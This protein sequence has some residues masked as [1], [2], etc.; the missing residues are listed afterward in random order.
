MTALASVPAL[1]A[2]EPAPPATTPPDSAVVW[3]RS[4]PFVGLVQ[5]MLDVRLTA[6]L[7][8]GVWLILE[9]QPLLLLAALV[10]WMLVLLLVLLR[11]RRLAAT[12]MSHP[13]LHLADLLATAAMTAVAGL[14]SP[15]SFLLLSGALFAGLC[16]GR[17]G[18]WYLTPTYLVCWLLAA[19]ATMP[20]RA[21]AGL[22]FL[23]LVAVPVL[24][25]GLLF[26]GSSFQ[27]AVL[28]A[29][30]LEESARQEREL[31]AVAEERARLAREL[32]DSVTKSL[33]GIGLLADAM[34]RLVATDPERAAVQA[35][36]LASAA[37][38][39][40]QESRELLVSMRRADVRAGLAELLRQ[41]VQ[42]WE[43]QHGRR[44]TTR[45]PA[46]PAVD[47]GTLYEIGALVNESLDN[48]ARH[49]PADTTVTLGCA[50]EDG[51]LTLTLAD[52][53]PGFCPDQA[54]A[55]VREGHY[56]LVGMGE[57]AARIGAL[58]DVDSAP[59][60]G[61]VV[62]LRVPLGVTR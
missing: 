29:L 7:L 20:E 38:I 32:H 34:P 61:T 23:V 9:H 22:G 42:R 8:A 15:F 56:G 44:V 25:V 36:A 26:A 12:V 55:R 24:M 13:L 2:A 6:G 60:A 4:K 18:A 51:W 5:V 33:Y 54:R 16:L 53:G 45:V 41:T 37:R 1:L 59:G 11:W 27:T 47:P 28:R 49:T 43:A 31:A 58:L 62:R 30:R 14:V 52:D 57:R 40:S 39:A 35:A 21:G 46:L 3:A 10:A 17:R 48:V 19:V 50:A